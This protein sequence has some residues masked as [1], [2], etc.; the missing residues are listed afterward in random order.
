M[1][2][3]S[4]EW[5]T[6]VWNPL[7]AFDR[8]TGKRGWFCTRV[9]D[10]CKNC[11]AAV[12]N[13]R[14]GNGHDY[15][16]RNLSKIEWRLVNLDEPLRA[17]KPRRY[18]VNSMTDLFH[19]DVPDEFI[20]QV[21]AVMAIATQHTFQILTKR[22]ERAAAW[23]ADDA[24]GA[25]DGL[26]ALQHETATVTE[27]PLPNVWLGTSVEDQQRADER[28]PHLLRTPAAVRF[29]SCEPLLGPIDF[30]IDA[31]RAGHEGVWWVDALTGKHDDMGRPCAPLPRIDWVIVG[32][33][34]G[35]GA[36]PFNIAWAES[37]IEQC[38][39]A[40]V[41]CFV[42]QLGANPCRPDGIV[43]DD[44][45]HF[46]PASA[47]HVIGSPLNDRKGG[48]IEEWPAQLRV[49]EFPQVTT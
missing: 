41:A 14:L 10:G 37:L 39:R 24:R 9:S 3:T 28:I 29:L 13:K 47:A 26:L 46:A 23:M 43:R 36:R 15:Q 25:V 17:R 31:E 49:R 22:P 8:T 38:R 30:N 19:E 4:I 35:P 5:A 40:G 7:A 11:Y 21:F 27:W 32:G 2:K 45:V 18:F 16:V 6:H 1:S 20:D 12:I 48:N 34:S 42:K 44:T 33:E